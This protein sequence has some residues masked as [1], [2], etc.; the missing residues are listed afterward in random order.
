MSYRYGMFLNPQS[1]DPRLKDFLEA[2]KHAKD[3]STT[4]N[5]APVAVWNDKDSTLVLFAGHE[6]FKPIK[7]IYG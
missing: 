4:N 6:E 2:K 3:L 1:D 7:Q 5:G